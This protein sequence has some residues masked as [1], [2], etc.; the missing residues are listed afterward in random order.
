MDSV[1]ADEL[2]SVVAEGE[3]T[4]AV[5]ILWQDG[6]VVDASTV[7]WQDAV[8]GE[9]MR[10]DTLFRIA[11]MT[12]PI[13]ST[14]ALMLHEEGRFALDDPITQWAPEMTNLRVLQGGTGSPADAVAAR[15][16]ITFGDLL[17]HRSGITY[18][19]FQHGTF[20]EDYAA[21][22][23]R[24]IDNELT[25]D[26]WVE[27]LGGLPLVDQP[28]SNFHYGHST[29][30]LGFLVARMEDAPLADVFDRRLLD[31]LGM[32]DTG[33]TLTA[34]QET[35]RAADHG[36]DDDGHP[37]VLD[38]VPNGHALARR[39]PGLTWVSGGQGLW[40]TADDFLT[41]A[42]MFVGDGA[43]DGVRLLRPDT[44]ALMTSNHLTEHQRA[45]AEMLGRHLFSTGHGYGLG[46]AVVTDPERADPT[47]CGG[48]VGAVGWPGAYGS[49]WQADPDDRSVMVLLT[50]NMV[51]LDQLSQGV[52]FGAWDAIT[53]FQ[54]VGSAMLAAQ[55]GQGGS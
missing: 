3:L 53:R 49:W 33:F 4:G 46:V 14:V 34:E 12:K 16:D 15:R 37:V 18:A 31:A 32:T 48:G 25:P 11:S 28:G 41:F 27:R 39:P 10:R 50:H 55:G 2:G 36:F 29:D 47:V 9:A 5:T 52:G 23:G 24:H 19:E 1:I 43:V 44:L 7:G 8:G 13:T 21:A 35:R 30:L 38:E 51:T 17:T 26:E 6:R 20:A 22:L 54:S 42:R 40:S 45:M